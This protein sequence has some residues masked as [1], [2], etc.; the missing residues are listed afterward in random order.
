MRLWFWCALFKIISFPFDQSWHQ[1]S[2]YIQ[3][4]L[5]ILIFILQMCLKLYKF[6]NWVVFV[7]NYRNRKIKK[8]IDWMKKKMKWFFI[9]NITSFFSVFT[10]EFQRIYENQAKT[11]RNV[12]VKN[13]FK[14]C[15]LSNLKAVFSL[16]AIAKIHWFVPI[17][18]W[19]Q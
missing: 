3:F 10:I 18:L 12:F 5:I 16:N 1:T 17:V 15:M 2:L 7:N 8:L 14:F 4:I 19:W 6:S 9:L 13:T 11:N